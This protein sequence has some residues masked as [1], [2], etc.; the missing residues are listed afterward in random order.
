MR[1]LLRQGL[2]IRGHEESEGNLTRLVKL[3]TEDNPTIIQLADSS[4]YTSP[5]IM[6]ELVSLMGN[7]LLRQVLKEI[8]E[9][10]WFAVIADETRDITNKEQLS[11]S[12]R[13]V[14]EDYA[15][16]EDPLGLVQVPKTDAAT[17][18]SAIKDV[19]IRCALPLSQCRGQA[20]DGASNMSGPRSGVAKRV[21]EEEP[22]ALPVHCLAHCLN[23]CLQDVTRQIKPIRDAL[24][25]VYEI[26]GL[27]KFSPKREYLFKSLQREQS[28]NSPN[29]KPL[30]P[31]RW[32]CRTASINAVLENYDILQETFE[33]VNATTQDDYGRKAGGIHILMEKFST[34]FGLKLAHLVFSAA[35][36]LSVTLQAKDTT[37]QD[38]CTAA[39]LAKAFYNR[40]RELSEFQNFY[41]KVLAEANDKTEPPVLPRYR[42]APK[43]LD[44]GSQPHRFTSPEEFYR[45]HYFQVM[46]SL[47]G[48]ITKRFEQKGFHVASQVESLIID[49]SNGTMCEIPEQMKEVYSRD[50]NWERLKIQL[51]ML[52]D[53]IESHNEDGLPIKK[54][55]TLRTL[56]DVLNS[57]ALSKKM[58][59]EV[60]SLLRLYYTL[61]V[62]SATAERTF[63]VLRRMK[64]Y[65]RSSMTQERLNNAMILHIYKELT[66]MLDLNEIAE[67]FVTVNER[68]QNYFGSFK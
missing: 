34:F 28:P 55:T 67:M 58:F 1:Y 30:C 48:E 11:V 57:S 60:H 13:W 38:A 53:L 56:C 19:L 5:E 50:L 52:P 41:Q 35:E 54:V 39:N 31:T 10:R 43:R 33:N 18:T 44:D 62:T 42:H 36:Q 27:I 29:L 22:S 51:A 8:R 68:R 17:L 9:A 26:I 37:V 25:L 46:E 47:S 23:L 16:H 12:I 59:S 6:N 66:D 49:H 24:D 63:S 45:Q 32:T 3:R 64:T 65:L 61:P 40:H 4:K 21:C 7:H 20:Y 15:I 2:A 14:G